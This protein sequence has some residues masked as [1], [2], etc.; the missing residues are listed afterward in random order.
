MLKDCRPSWRMYLS[1]PCLCV[2][3]IFL[4]PDSIIY[5]IHWLSSVLHGTTR[6]IFTVL[7]YFVPVLQYSYYGNVYC[8]IFRSFWIIIASI[9]CTIL[10][11][12]ILSDVFFDN[13]IFR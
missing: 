12:I 2:R 1:C 6:F 9:I 13:C 7:Y 10:D 11:G 4:F 3:S 5:V 8:V